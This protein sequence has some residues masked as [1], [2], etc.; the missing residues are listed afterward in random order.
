MES[1]IAEFLVRWPACERLP[2]F[3][4][5]RTSRRW[6]CYA[7]ASSAEVIDEFREKA[8]LPSVLQLLSCSE[9]AATC[10]SDAARLAAMKLA[11]ITAFI[12]AR[13]NLSPFTKGCRERDASM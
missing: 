1:S 10:K 4:L 11:C 6:P 7:A 2:T 12:S 3:T 13:T 9:T 8:M 5:I